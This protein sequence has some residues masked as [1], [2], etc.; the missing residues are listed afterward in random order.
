MLQPL[1]CKP[2]Q[3]IKRR[4]KLGLIGVKKNFEQVKQWIGERLNKDQ[5]IGNAV[6]KLRNFIIEPFVP[7]T[8]VSYQIVYYVYVYLTPLYLIHKAEEMYVCIYSH[9]AADTILFYHQGGV[10]IGDVDAKAVKLDVPV[11]SSLSLADVKSKLLKEVKDAGT[12]ERIAK[13]VSA[14]YTTYVDLYFTYLEINPLVVTAD[15]LYILDLAAKLDSTADFICRPK[16]GEIDYPPPFGRDAYPE[17]AYIADLDAKS[18]ASLKLTILNRN[19]RIWTMVAGGGASVIYSDTICDLG[20]ASELANYGEYSGA[21]SEQQTYEY[22]KTI[23]NLMTSSPKHPDGKVLITGGGIANFTNVAATFQ[24]E[25][26]IPYLISDLSKSLCA[27]IITALRE[28]QPK[29]VEHNVSI[30][31]RRAGPNYQEGLRKMRDFGSTLGIPLHVF[32]PETHMTAIC[33]M[34]LGKR[35]IPQTASVEFSTANFLLPGGQQAQAD[36]KA[37]SDASEALGSGSGK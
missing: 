23:L 27:G 4:G 13:F 22:A 21:P 26:L 29:L 34:A 18:G 25:R 20:G 9:R 2:D 17:E 36:L 33:G 8:D 35:P 10:D 7:H 37:A 11:N 30:F 15:N 31:V 3:L 12:K 24:G 5:K 19:G 14:L 16:W 1:V 28:F 6:G 32:G